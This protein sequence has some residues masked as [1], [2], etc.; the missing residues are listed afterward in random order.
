[1]IRKARGFFALLLSA[2]VLC[3][4]CGTAEVSENPGFKNLLDSVVKIDVWTKTQDDGS[5]RMVRG[6]GSGAIMDEDGYIIT[7]AHVANMYAVKIVVTLSSLEKVDAHFVGWDHWTDLAV[8]RLDMADVKRRGLKFSHA[9]FGDFSR[10]KVG[11][12]VYAVGTPH[13]FAR[14]ATRGI[15]SNLGRF[16][17]GTILDSGY[18]T[19]NFNTWIQTDAAIN[20]GNS[21]GPLVLP[22]GEIIGINTR[23]YLGASNLAFSIPADVA[24]GVMGRIISEGRVTRSYVGI[25]PAPLQDMESFFDLDVNKGVLIRN[26]D[27]GSPAA[28]AGVSAGDI[29]LKI[30]SE[31]VDGRFPEQIPAIMNSIASMK[32][33]SEVTLTILHG[34]K[35]SECKL[36]T[37]LLE[38]RVGEEFPLEKWGLGMREITKVYAR[39]AKLN[40]DSKLLI[41]GVRSGFPAEIANLREGDVIVSVNRKKVGT[42]AELLEAYE[43]NAK[44]E[45]DILIEVLRDHSI[46]YHILKFGG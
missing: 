21:G 10:V 44:L 5:S 2:C 13:G 28:R 40:T 8:L 3:G 6:V 38:S 37:E 11:D 29:L 22:S 33:G 31:Q 39:E 32:V 27:A 34:R 26:V 4:C 46:G 9:R 18:E 43:A 19:G 16:F 41:I 12:V 45:K 7:N 24:R 14:T 17:E 36:E 42:K 30:N 1:M 35:I 15:I 25:T 23:A 20:P